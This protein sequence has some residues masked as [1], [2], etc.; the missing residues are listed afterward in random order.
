DINGNT[1]SCEQNIFIKK[2]NVTQVKFPLAVE[3]DC[4]NPNIG[5]TN[6][7][8]PTINGIPIGNDCNLTVT[9]VDGNP[10][11]TCGGGYTFVRQRF[12]IEWCTSE[13]NVGNQVIEITDTNPPSITC[14]N[15]I[16][17]S[18]TSNDCMGSVILPTPI[19]SDDCSNFITSIDFNFPKSGNTYGVY[20]LLLSAQPRLTETLRAVLIAKE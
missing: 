2:L 14:P 9:I 6:T 1:N 10:I 12:V 7:G 4:S 20:S 8:F 3:I 5:P 16:S 13:A 11:P 19:V 18:T 15:D 17:I